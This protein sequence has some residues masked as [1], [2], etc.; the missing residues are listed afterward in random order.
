VGVILV[1][2]LRHIN[3]KNDFL[4]EITLHFYLILLL[5]YR[6][7]EI[8]EKKKNVLIFIASFTRA[9]HNPLQKETDRIIRDAIASV[10]SCKLTKVAVKRREYLSMPWTNTLGNDV[11]GI[12][13]S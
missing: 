6:K 1:A 2:L 3:S 10:I 4:R 13:V 12:I 11:E 7:K 9:E 8:D 5:R